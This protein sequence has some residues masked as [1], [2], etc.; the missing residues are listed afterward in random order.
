MRLCLCVDDRGDVPGTSGLTASLVLPPEID[1]ARFEMVYEWKP[2]VPLPNLLADAI[3][4]GTIDFGEW[5]RAWIPEGFSG[6]VAFDVERW[7]IQQS[8]NSIEQR[9]ALARKH[10]T[11]TWG[12]AIA[13]FLSKAETAAKR[14]RP[15]IAG[16]SWYG[17]LG[18][19]PDQI[20]SFD[21]KHF[22][23]AKRDAAAIRGRISHPVLYASDRKRPASIYQWAMN[24]YRN[25][26]VPNSKLW[27]IINAR[28]PETATFTTRADV[29]AQLSAARG[30]ENV[31]LWDALDSVAAARGFERWAA[32][33]LVPA[34]AEVASS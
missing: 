14:V 31:L 9:D 29:V 4:P 33:V 19:H 24:L 1:R 8:V 27:P 13:D 11:L 30:S 5:V 2:G 22:A 32:E 20:S 7:S 18:W 23:E 21:A 26:G 15:T 12:E 10:P 28:T 3:A 25:V 6:F 34:A 16:V 17:M